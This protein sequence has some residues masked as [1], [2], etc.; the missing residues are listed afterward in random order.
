MLGNPTGTAVIV[1]NRDGKCCDAGKTDRCI[2]FNI[3]LDND[4]VGLEIKINGATP[5]PHEWDVDCG[6]VSINNGVVCIPGGDFH[7]FTFCKPGANAETY[8]FRSIPA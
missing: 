2:S 4:A 5:Q 3:R 7:L 8:T 6:D 1:D